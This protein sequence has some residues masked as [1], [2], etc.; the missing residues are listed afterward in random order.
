M[1]AAILVSTAAAALLNAAFL[2]KQ[3]ALAIAAGVV[4]AIAIQWSK[5]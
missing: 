5:Q 4:F 1:G 3:P 2:L